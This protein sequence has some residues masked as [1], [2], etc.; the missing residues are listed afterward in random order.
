[1]GWWLQLA[2]LLDMSAQS[3]DCRVSS[4]WKPVSPRP[5]PLGKTALNVSNREGTDM[6]SEDLSYIILTPL[7][8]E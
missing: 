4:Q 7:T 3:E 5:W 8:T 1:M 2:I 6:A